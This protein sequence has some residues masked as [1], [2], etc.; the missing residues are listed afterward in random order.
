MGSAV[1]FLPPRVVEGQKGERRGGPHLKRYTRVNRVPKISE[2]VSNESSCGR[3][4]PRGER[5]YA[6]RKEKVEKRGRARPITI[7]H[8]MSR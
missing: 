1:S 5:I 6:W 2:I 4:V 3:Y 8:L 7:S